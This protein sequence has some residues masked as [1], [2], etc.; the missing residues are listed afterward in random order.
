M[1]GYSG[2][3]G[4]SKKIV[5]SE[6]SESSA[7]RKTF[8]NIFKNSSRDIKIIPSGSY[9]NLYRLN[10]AILSLLESDFARCEFYLIRDRD[11]LSQESVEKHRAKLPDRLFVLNRYHIENYLLEEV[12]VSEILRTIYQKELSADQ[13]RHEF[14]EIARKNSA[15]FFR[16]LV[17][18]RFGDL[19]QPEDCSI[20]NH[21]TNQAIVTASSEIDAGVFELLRTALTSKLADVNNAV[22]T[23]TISTN[24]NQILDDCLSEVKDAL[25]IE[26]DRWKELFPGRY[27]L[28]KFSSM[29][30]LGD[31]PALQNLII[32]HLSKGNFLVN[33]ELKGIFDMIIHGPER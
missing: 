5:F 28:Q 18:F 25:Q 31:W 12:L 19:Y 26:N 14:F 4:I 2:Y 27:I 21:S 13:I 7:D 29:H 32:D 22:S 33:S 20:G 6:G 3:V 8:A 10:A 24:T 15:A 30:G 1:F 23:R 11:Y 17:V 16:D 9:T